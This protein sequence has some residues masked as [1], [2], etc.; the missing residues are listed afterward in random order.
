MAYLNEKENYL[1]TKMS[2]FKKR[3]NVVQK[4]FGANDRRKNEKKKEDYKV[5]RSV[6]QHDLCD[7]CLLALH[8]F[9]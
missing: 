4:T 8:F 5:H 7:F 3:E 9:I 2:N 1:E 6:P